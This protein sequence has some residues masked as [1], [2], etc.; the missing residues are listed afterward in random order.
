MVA[1][2]F[3]GSMLGL[4]AGNIFFAVQLRGETDPLAG[5]WSALGILIF[6]F[7]GVVLGGLLGATTALLRR[8]SKRSQ[9]GSPSP[10]PPA[11]R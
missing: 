10:L 7:W 6:M 5:E 1:G 11:P 8:A 4:L 3:I 2:A 9:Q